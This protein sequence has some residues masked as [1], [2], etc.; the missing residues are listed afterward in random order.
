VRLIVTCDATAEANDAA[1]KAYVAGKAN[2]AQGA[3]RKATG[4][5]AAHTMGKLM[6][7]AVLPPIREAAFVE[8]ATEPVHLKVEHWR[9][10]QKE[11]HGCRNGGLQD[12]T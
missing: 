4:Q 10:N 3:S 1:W 6:P 11:A 2:L 7:T 8:E 5:V 12:H 9:W